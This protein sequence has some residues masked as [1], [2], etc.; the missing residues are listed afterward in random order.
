MLIAECIFLG[1]I[2][3]SKFLREK[4]IQLGYPDRAEIHLVIGC[5][6]YRTLQREVERER[7]TE[8]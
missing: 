1:D 2:L 4:E 7:V 5:A 3:S 8:R 6:G